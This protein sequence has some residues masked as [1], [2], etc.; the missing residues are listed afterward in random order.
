MRFRTSF[1]SSHRYVGSYAFEWTIA[2][3]THNSLPLQTWGITISA[4]ILQNEL[5]K[6]LPPAFAAQFPQGVEIAYALIP[7]IPTLEDPLRTDVR[8]AFA[9][10]MSIVWKAMLGI[11]AGGLLTT[12]LLKEI[13]LHTAKDD[14]YGLEQ[15][16]TS[17]STLVGL[18][19]VEKA[20][21]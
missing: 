21:K 15:E 3:L 8:I 19:D 5:K 16:K 17:A 11:S 18:T 13:Q 4:S 20:D 9:T 14:R 6:S 7:I 10:S 2:P 1:D 12:F